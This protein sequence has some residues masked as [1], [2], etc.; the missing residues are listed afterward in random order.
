MFAT[1]LKDLAVELNVS[2]FTA[3][4]VNAKIDDNK[5][6]R[7]ESALA[8]GRSTINKA[9]NGAIIARP[10]QEEL[11][12]VSKLHVMQPNIV[13]DIF[14]VRSGEWN[15]VRIWSYMDLGTMR[16]QDLFITDSALE[17]IQDFFDG[18]DVETY[19]ANWE[20]EVAQ[21]VNN[22]INKMNEELRKL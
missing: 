7:N 18:F 4:Q 20:D 8:G 5:D 3:T 1:A 19:S 11:E 17:P 9:D 6:I 22:L 12:V 13:T 15:Q 2:V 14:K 21:Q 16:K 10:T